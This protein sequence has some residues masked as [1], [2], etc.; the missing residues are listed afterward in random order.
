V[1]FESIRLTFG[2]LP[3]RV[4]AN[5]FLEGFR[6]SEAEEVEEDWEDDE[7]QALNHERDLRR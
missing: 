1:K 3:L 7:L 5:H 4:L 2:Q 6:K